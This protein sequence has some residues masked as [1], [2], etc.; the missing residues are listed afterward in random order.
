M[1]HPPISSLLEVN[2]TEYSFKINQA[3]ITIMEK[4]N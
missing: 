4:N 1:N 3:T 2:L